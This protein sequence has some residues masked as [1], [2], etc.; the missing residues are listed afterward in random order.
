MARLLRRPASL[1]RQPFSI[2]RILRDESPDWGFPSWGIPFP[3]TEL[4]LDFV[5]NLFAE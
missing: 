4:I 2:P 5:Y 1:E 3:V